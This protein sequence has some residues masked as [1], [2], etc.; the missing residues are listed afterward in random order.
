MQDPLSVAESMKH[1]SVPGGFQAELFASDPD[2]FKPICLSWDDKGRLWIAETKD[3][4][5][6]KERDDQGHDRITICE[7]TDGDGKADKFTVFA[8]HLSIPT[9]MVHV[10]DGLIVT[11]APDVLFFADTDGDDRADVK[12]VLF[13]GFST[14]DTHAGPSNLR[15]GFDG[16]I[17]ATVG[18]AGFNGEVGGK[19]H[20]FNQSL[21]RFKP[22]GSDL[23]VLTSTSNN[24]WG[25]GLTE[26][27]EVVYSTANGEHSSYLGLP[28]SAFESVRG[29]LGKGNDRMA[30]HDRMRPLTT[31]R[32]VDWFGGFTAAAGHAV[33]TARQYPREFW[34]RIAFVCEPTGH[35]VHMCQLD[36]QGSHLVSHDRFNL[37][38]STDEWTSPI[39]AEVGPDGTVWVVDWY[40]YVVQHNPTPLGFE[41]GK[42]NAYVTPLRDKTHGRIYR[43]VNTSSPLSKT[44]DLTRA[45]PAQLVDAL[46]SDNMLW[47]MK[48][49]WRLIARGKLDVVPALV[50]LVS[51]R[52][53]DEFD[54]KPSAVHALCTLRGL[55][56]LDRDHPDAQASLEA[57]LRHPAS[58]VRLAALDALPRSTRSVLAILNA[59]LLDGPEPGGPPAGS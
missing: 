41:T 55:G 28:N 46:K 16:W 31:I 44:Y 12:K 54:Q 14:N 53:L 50:G 34:D 17:Y 18:Y 11:S 6:E 7:D 3:Y 33:Y 21:F 42:G 38:A 1:I 15:L 2:I 43:V 32:Q 20:R 48:A 8:D 57:A 22:D 27:G 26:T 30:D 4:P 59:N 58:G 29:W 51:D 10:P 45:T 19:R 35:L 9:S 47:R 39:V 49:Q 56:V 37:F 24:T 23:E 5:N 52:Q 40:N 13:T 25:L 36:R